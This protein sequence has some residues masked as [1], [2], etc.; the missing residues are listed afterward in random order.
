M[1]GRQSS[2]PIRY[3]D[4]LTATRPHRR[5]VRRAPSP[6]PSIGAFPV[7]NRVEKPAKKREAI[8]SPEPETRSIRR[9]SVH[10]RTW[11]VVD[12]PQSMGNDLC[13]RF[14]VFL[15]SNTSA[16]MRD[17]LV[18]GIPWRTIHPPGRTVQWWSRTSDRRDCPL[19]PSD[20][21]LS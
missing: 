20:T 11:V 7:A 8:P 19:R 15:V 1:S 17:G 3:G 21:W 2:T 10:E 16:A 13:D 12:R 9:E 5:S 4:E 14:G 18:T 6:P